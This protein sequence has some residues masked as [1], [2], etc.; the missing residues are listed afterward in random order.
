MSIKNGLR[1]K[2]WSKMR[3]IAMKVYDLSKFFKVLGRASF[4]YPFKLLKTKYLTELTQEKMMRD[5]VTVKFWSKT[6]HGRV[7]ISK[8]SNF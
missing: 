2:I 4:F 8:N 7:Q 5:L 6:D 1:F 3:K